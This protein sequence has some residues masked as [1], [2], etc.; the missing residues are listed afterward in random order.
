MQYNAMIE[1][2]DNLQDVAN[3]MFKETRY[4]CTGTIISSQYFIAEIRK[5]PDIN[6][7][8]LVF[9]I[10]YNYTHILYTKRSFD[11]SGR[12]KTYNILHN[13]KIVLYLTSKLSINTV[14]KYLL[15]PLNNHRLLSHVISKYNDAD[16]RIFIEYVNKAEQSRAVYN[17]YSLKYI[18]KLCYMLNVPLT[19]NVFNGAR[20][21]SKSI[22]DTI[23]YYAKMAIILNSA[24]FKWITECLSI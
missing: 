9:L 21:V 14:I 8:D 6:Y 17:R 20:H 7:D 2:V 5:Y 1:L 12:S 19:I 13:K 23:R 3:A 22:D 4:E 15:V 18:I 11:C 10:D 16:K 24:R